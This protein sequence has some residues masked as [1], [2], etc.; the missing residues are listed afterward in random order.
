MPGP[1]SK[2]PPDEGMVDLDTFE[3]DHAAERAAAAR[4]QEQNVKD[5][6]PASLTREHLRSLKEQ[7]RKAIDERLRDRRRQRKLMRG[8]KAP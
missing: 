7:A 5:D 6:L 2:D 3:R 4:E 1:R 8:G